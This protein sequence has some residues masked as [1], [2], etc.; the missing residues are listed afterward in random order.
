MLK[1]PRLAVALLA[2]RPTLNPSVDFLVRDDADGSGPYLVEGSMLNPPSQEEV[3]ALTEAQLNSAI[4]RF[5]GPLSVTAAQAK[6][7]LYN[8]GYYDMVKAAV[9]AY[10][11]MKLYFDNAPTWN[12]TNPYVLGMAAELEIEDVAALFDAAYELG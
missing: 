1:H 11:P 7:A 5:N 12:E 10:P 6:L 3:D 9:E 4:R 8:A 2:L